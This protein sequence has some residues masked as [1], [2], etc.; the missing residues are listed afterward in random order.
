GTWSSSA[1]TGNWSSASN[2]VAGVIPGATAGTTDADTAIFNSGSTTTLVIPDLTRNLE[3]ITF[4]T[5]AAAYTIGTTGGNA[6]LLTS[7]GTIQT[8]FTVV[9]TEIINA[10]LVIEGTNGLYSFSSGAIDNNKVLNF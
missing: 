4:D 7:G 10:P 3:F 5:A 6:L 9:N 1:S 2:W 8:T